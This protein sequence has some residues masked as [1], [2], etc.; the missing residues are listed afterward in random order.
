MAARHGLGLLATD[1]MMP[2]HASRIT[3]EDC[4]FLREFAAIGMDERWVNRSPETMLET[5]HWFRGEGFCLIVE[6]L[7][8]RPSES[9]MIVE[10]FR[11]SPRLVKPIQKGP[12]AIC[13]SVTG[14]S[15]NASAGKRSISN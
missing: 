3:L 4:P 11:L 12:C 8:R 15:P 1:D 6:D 7:L 13:S 2:D 14:C 9:R 5:F 10:G